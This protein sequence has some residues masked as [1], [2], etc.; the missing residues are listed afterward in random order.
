MLQKPVTLTERWKRILDF[1]GMPTI[2]EDK[3]E[4]IASLIQNQ[5]VQTKRLMKESSGDI[6]GVSQVTGYESILIPVLRRIAPD[7]IAFD[8]FG[9][10]PMERPSQQIFALRTH[11]LG[12]QGEAST[13]TLAYGMDANNVS[14]SQII[15]VA[16]DDI[17]SF[18]AGAAATPSNGYDGTTFLYAITDPTAVSTV[19]ATVAMTRIGTVDYVEDGQTCLVRLTLSGAT[20]AASILPTTLLRTD[21]TAGLTTCTVTA[22]Q[23][24][25][26][27]K[28]FNNE[29]MYNAVLRYYSGPYTNAAAE[30]MKTHNALTVSIAKIT[31][32]AKERILRAQ[33]SFQVAE[34]MKSY[35]N[36]EAENE[37]L[38][39][40]SYEILAE[41]NREAA[42]FVYTAAEDGRNQTY[43]WDYTAASGTWQGEKTRSLFNAINKVASDVGISSRRSNANIL[44]VSP[45]VKTALLSL[46]GYNHWDDINPDFNNTAAVAYAGKMD[47]FKVFVDTFAIDDFAYLG[48]KG[49]TEFD[50][51]AFYCPYIPL[52]VIRATGQNDFQPRIAFRTRYGLQYN[53]F[54]G[55]LYYKKIGITGLSNVWNV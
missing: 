39:A 18:W 14:K 49:K 40:L 9:T 17:T 11:Y 48:Y 29:T 12:D 45:N 52:N 28:I 5:Y 6:F 47:T 8:I 20:V 36:L 30:A 33:Y 10:Q 51:G 46:E 2:R 21:L 53:P 26:A 50:A 38:N 44:I 27:T 7:L 3:R 24:A 31:V 34:D 23:C 43:T 32:E 41:M 25:Y 37:L 16:D 35:H 4:K 22:S 55:Y 13:A 54:G 19:S 42:E 1:P 15:I